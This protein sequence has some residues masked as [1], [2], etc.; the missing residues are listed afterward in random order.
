M[1]KV[2]AKAISKRIGGSG[3][4][5]IKKRS[6]AL[7]EQE[8]KRKRVSERTPA[9]KAFLIRKQKERKEAAERRAKNKGGTVSVRAGRL[10]R[11]NEIVREVIRKA[12]ENKRKK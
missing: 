8:I 11:G 7:N 10:K 12:Q 9:D 1:K 3:S 4:G 2:L 6:R 5:K